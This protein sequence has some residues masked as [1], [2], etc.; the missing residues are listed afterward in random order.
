MANRNCTITSTNGETGLKKSKI[1]SKMRN[2]S[3]YCV[4]CVRSVKVIV[5]VVQAPVY[6]QEM[7]TN[8]FSRGDNVTNDDRAEPIKVKNQ[9]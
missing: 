6:M 9:A 1:S 4:S 8:Y 5:W 7:E 3:I 2:Y